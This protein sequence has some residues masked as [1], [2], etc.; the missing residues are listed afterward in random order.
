[1]KLQESAEMYLEN[2][3][4]LSMEQNEV[5]SIDLANAMS[6][7]KPSV[8]RAV[9]LLKDGGYL[10]MDPDGLLKLTPKGEA[11]AVRV[12]QRHLAL[13]CWLESL[14]VSETTASLD[15]CR[16]E[17]VLSDESFAAIH[18]D[19]ERRGILHPEAN[20]ESLRQWHRAMIAGSD[21]ALK[22]ESDKRNRK[23]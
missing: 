18:D 10:D 13:M 4:I 6:Y 2:I 21:A 16:M 1:M 12:Y 22:E 3:F 7:S 19:L 11:Y 14:G 20:P 9:H 5:R 17:H 8:S 15:A 23:D